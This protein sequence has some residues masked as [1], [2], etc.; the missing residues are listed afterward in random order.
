MAK[1]QKMVHLAGRMTVADEADLAERMLGHQAE[2]YRQTLEAEAARLGCPQTAASP[3]GDELEALQERADWAAASIAGT[4][5][6]NLAKEIRLIGEVTPTANR[7]VYASRLYYADGAWD[8]EYWMSKAVEVAQVESITVI[9]AAVSDFYAHNDG[10]ISPMAH[11]IPYLAICDLCQEMVAGN[12]YSSVAEVFRLYEI[13]PHPGCP[14]QAESLPAR[15]LSA[16]ECAL[17][18]M[19][20]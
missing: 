18:W 12:P 16:E 17:L 9:N 5:N 10:I 4:Y 2:T 14:H 7:H 3:T 20:G 1:V 8:R 11:V 13:P 19:G 15:R 6:L